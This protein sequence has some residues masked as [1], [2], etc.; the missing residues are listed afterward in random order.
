[1]QSHFQTLV[2]FELLGFHNL[3][4]DFLQTSAKKTSKTRI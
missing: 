3:T 2:H 4:S 1:M